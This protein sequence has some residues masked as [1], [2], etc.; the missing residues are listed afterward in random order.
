MTIILL[1]QIINKIQET[2][3]NLSK[4]ILLAITSSILS[5][6]LVKNYNEYI[7]LHHNI[8][9][10]KDLKIL[11]KTYS[12][13][14]DSSSTKIDN[15]KKEYTSNEMYDMCKFLLKSNSFFYKNYNGIQYNYNYFKKLFQSSW[16]NIFQ[17]ISLNQAVLKD[18]VLKDEL[19]NILKELENFNM[20]LP[21]QYKYITS[22]DK[23]TLKQCYVFAHKQ[24]VKNN[25][26]KI[27]NHH[28]ENV[29]Q[30]WLKNNRSKET[31]EINMFYIYFVY[32]I[33]DKNN[34][35]NLQ[36]NIIHE[37]IQ[38]YLSNTTISEKKK[39]NYQN[40]LDYMSFFWNHAQYYTI[41][42][43]KGD[44]EIYEQCKK[45]PEQYSNNM[46]INLIRQLVNTGE[47]NVDD[48]LSEID[49]DIKDLNKAYRQFRILKS[50][51]N[52]LIFTNEN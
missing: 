46:E 52:K 28:D 13:Y 10:P 5:G 31:Y 3:S 40:I 9:F 19:N 12:L 4:E 38:V 45:D 6:I 24:F 30:S 29:I 7:K 8:F 16:E 27:I 20:N 26:D 35:I 39:K 51:L 32:T 41:Q 18:C 42:K 2:F 34:D 43:L 11:I 21:I 25:I 48:K 1:G 23:E 37:I 47:I 15:Y 14:N 33:N 22:I 17:Y 44:K 49:K 36:Q 50:I